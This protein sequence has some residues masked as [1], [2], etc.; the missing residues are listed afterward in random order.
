MVQLLSMLG[1]IVLS[2]CLIISGGMMLF[3]PDR[4]FRSE[5]KPRWLGL[6]LLCMGL[7]GAA[8]VISS[9]H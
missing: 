4:A 1:A 8:G 3:C 6:P 5:Y 7:V 2:L 9:M